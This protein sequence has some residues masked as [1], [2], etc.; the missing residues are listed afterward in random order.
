MNETALRQANQAYLDYHQAT[1]QNA[2]S[3]E[4]IRLLEQWSFLYRQIT[5]G[6]PLTSVRRNTGLSQSC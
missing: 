5:L 3:A 6:A 2:S 4:R 1:K